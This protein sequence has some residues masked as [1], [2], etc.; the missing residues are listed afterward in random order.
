MNYD[1]IPEVLT[2]EDLKRVLKIGTNK[3]YEIVNQ[4]S[5]P[6]VKI[7]RQIRIPKRLFLQWLESQAFKD[8][9]NIRRFYPPRRVL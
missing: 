6:K 1:D 9:E 3:A 8:E 2:V 4:V 7:G 5:F